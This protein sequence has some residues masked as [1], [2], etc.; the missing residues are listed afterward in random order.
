MIFFW[1]LSDSK[2]PQVSRTLLSI[3]V[4][5]NNG[6][7]LMVSICS[8]IPKSFSPFANYLRLVPSEAITI[9]ITFTLMFHSFFSY[10][11]RFRYLSLFSFPFNFTLWSAGMAMATIRQVLFFLVDYHKVWLSGRD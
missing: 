5:L 3:L 8:L 6:V 10:L 1:S 2:S 11:A 9:G 4:D 7:V